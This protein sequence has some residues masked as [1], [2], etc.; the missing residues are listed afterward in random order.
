[1]VDRAGLRVADYALG[2]SFSTGEDLEAV[3][4]MLNESGQGRDIRNLGAILY[5]MLTGRPPW[6]PS[7]LIRSMFEESPDPP[8]SFND[9]VDQRLEL[10][11]LRCFMRTSKRGHDSAKSL[12]DDLARWRPRA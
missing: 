4:D 11:C 8:R 6:G 3:R 1:M 12:A 9:L 5:E 7:E 10:I 2:L